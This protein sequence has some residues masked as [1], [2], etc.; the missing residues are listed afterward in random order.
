MWLK[1]L[2][3]PRSLSGYLHRL[4]LERRFEQSPVVVRQ[5]VS[6]VDI[7]FEVHNWIEYHHRARDSYT[8]EPDT[9][10]W[11]TRNL[12]SGDVLWDIG[13]N[14]GAYS[15]L[16]AKTVPDSRVVA[17][18]PYIPSYSHLG[19]NISLNFCSQQITPLCAALSDHTKIDLLGISDPRA[20]SSEHVLGG[21][22]FKL[23][24][25]SMALKGDDAVRH[26][27]LPF[28]NLF[29]MDV[30]G[31]ELKV[32]EGMTHILQ[33]SEMRSA[34]IEVDA[35]NETEVST[36]LDR[37]GLIESGRQRINPSVS[38]IEFVRVDEN[39]VSIDRPIT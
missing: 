13:A 33:R 38:N 6:G 21:K 25:P 32:L 27:D 36:L 39:N 10:A 30:D 9:V 2:T 11:I 31:Y 22:E 23:A 7:A 24:Q 29:K 35:S 4:K 14:V 34:I 1:E 12:R 18:E 3:R 20:G 8:G 28:P 26:F 15:L 37:M 17:F 16:A 19:N 5:H